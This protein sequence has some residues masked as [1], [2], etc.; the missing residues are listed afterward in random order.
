MTSS[1]HG[2]QSMNIRLRW[3]GRWS[4]GQK[5]SSTTQD[6]STPAQNVEQSQ[7]KDMNSS[8]PLMRQ[9]EE[10]RDRMPSRPPVHR[11]IRRL[12]PKL[13]DLQRESPSRRGYDSRWTA[14]REWFLNMVAV[15]DTDARYEWQKY[16]SLAC[17]ECACPGSDNNPLELDHIIAIRKGGAKYDPANIKILCKSCHSKKTVREDGGLAHG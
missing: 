7:P 12:G 9:S 10:G 2:C 4:T 13:T 1:V 5:S 11:P 3:R 8:Q 14:W 15:A 16:R 6:T 17:E